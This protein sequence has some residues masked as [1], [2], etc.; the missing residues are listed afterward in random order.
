MDVYIAAD[1][2]E[3]SCEYR[4]TIAHERQHVGF[5][6]AVL[7]E[8]LPKVRAALTGAARDKFPASFPDTPTNEEVNHIL[9]DPVAPVFQAMNQDMARRNGSIDTPENYRREIAKCG[10]WMPHEAPR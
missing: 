6:L 3:D 2:P 1:Y 7:R 4:V 10:N 5:N 8:W 9:L